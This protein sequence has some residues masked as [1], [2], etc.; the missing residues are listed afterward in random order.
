MSKEIFKE[1]PNKLLN[2]SQAAHILGYKDH[3]KVELFIQQGLLT[4]FKLPHS[5]RYK[6]P[7]HD[8]MRLPSLIQSQS[9]SDS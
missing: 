8:V 1:Q 9:D 6:I 4:C 5:N 7:Y 2:L 3:R